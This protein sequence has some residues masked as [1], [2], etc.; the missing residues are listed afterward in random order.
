[1]FGWAKEK[2]K[3]FSLVIWEI[4]GHLSLSLCVIQQ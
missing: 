2:R 3:V 1:M 4:I